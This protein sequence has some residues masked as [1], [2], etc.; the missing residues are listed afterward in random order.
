MA[1]PG[2]RGEFADP[3]CS[4]SREMPNIVT[5]QGLRGFAPIH[6]PW[7][8]LAWPRIPRGCPPRLPRCGG[9]C[10]ALK[11][12]CPPPHWHVTLCHRSSRRGTTRSDRNG[13][14]ERARSRYGRQPGRQCGHTRRPTEPGRSACHYAHGPTVG[15]RPD[16]PMSAR[17]EVPTGCLEGPRKL[18]GRIAG[19]PIP[20]SIRPRVASGL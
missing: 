13:R 4:R 12:A 2:A 17:A 11:P 1:R 20:Q 10:G 18:P 8:M 15:R 16:L 7:S 19:F 9:P 5:C 3:L 14:E 6:A